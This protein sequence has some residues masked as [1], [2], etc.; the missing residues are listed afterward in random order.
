MTARLFACVNELDAIALVLKAIGETE[1]LPSA[2]LALILARRQWCE[3][4]VTHTASTRETHKGLCARR[5]QGVD[6]A[7][8]P[9]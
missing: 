2:I 7:L 1:L 6:A 4:E 8:V 3:G 9:T 5:R